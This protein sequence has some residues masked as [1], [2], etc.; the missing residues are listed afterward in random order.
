M[1]LRSLFANVIQI[2]ISQAKKLKILIRF[3]ARSLQSFGSSRVSYTRFFFFFF[4]TGDSSR[5]IEFERSRQKIREGIRNRIYSRT[6]ILPVIARHS[7]KEIAILRNSTKDMSQ[8]PLI[9]AEETS[10]TESPTC[11]MVILEVKKEKQEK[12]ERKK[13]IRVLQFFYFVTSLICYL[14]TF[15][16]TIFLLLSKFYPRFYFT[17]FFFHLINQFISF[18]NI[19]RLKKYFHLIF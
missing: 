13:Y 12:R 10:T 7:S 6:I 14:F 18:K 5:C 2:F 15:F 9:A 16:F 11:N 4:F 17:D 3:A 8:V 19:Q 1:F